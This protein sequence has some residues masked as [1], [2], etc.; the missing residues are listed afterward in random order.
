MP[1]NTDIQAVDDI[2]QEGKVVDGFVLG[3]E[4]H[5]GGMA[6]LF[7]ATKEGI[8]VPILLKIPRV[9]RD[10]PVE[11]LIGFETELTILRS[12]KSPYV[13]QYL[14]SGNMA[15][16]PYIAMERVGGRPLEDYIKE[17]KVFTIDEVV[18]IG[19]DLA[20]AVQ[21]LHSQDAIHLDVKPENILIDE[22]GKLTLID[23]GLSHHARY[24]DLLAE[25]MRKGIGSAPYISPEQ[26]AGIRSDSRSD[27]FSIGVI[28]YELL[29]GELPFGN[30]QTMSGLRKRMWAE[31]FPPRA[32]RREIPRWLQEVVLRCLEPRAAD[33]YQSAA[34]LRQ[35]LRDP[36]GVTLTERA[37]RVEPPS[38]WENLKGMFKAAGYE[39]SPSPRPSMG[40]L[41]A[42]LMI[43]AIDTRQ[44]DEALR[45]RMQ[46]TAK[47]LLQAHPESRLICLST[48]A[49]TPT[50]EGNHESQTASGIVRGHL[51]QLMEWAKPLK[52]PPERISYHVLEALDPASRIVE[53]A[54]DNDAS[55]I[56]IGASHKLPNKVT[57][58]RT[59][60]TK[61]V[62]EAPCSV[63][64]VRT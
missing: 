57:P 43:A 15:T 8:N 61:I 59:S 45:E 52:L 11:S 32:I 31:P 12:L 47:N 50:Y 24:P 42:P 29:T 5:R 17:G 48:I 60:M 7:S 46:I 54:K 21:S 39:P 6:S 63:H 49:S 23:F 34:R 53:F 20:Q 41:D 35:V 26:V 58:W 10:Q 51:V 30:P 37:D 62:E 1:I 33:R 28:M 16:R 3:K 44:S 38:F 36:E 19:A 9:G 64:I 40:S 22:K 56:L 27:I 13:P 55:L 25:E 14:G 2:F 18:R 4:V